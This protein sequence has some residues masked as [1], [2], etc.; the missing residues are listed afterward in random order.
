[1]LA[2]ASSSAGV[3][4]STDQHSALADY[5]REFRPTR[6]QLTPALQRLGNEPKARLVA[7]IEA[8]RAIVDADGERRPYEVKILAEIASDLDAI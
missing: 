2:P 4:L 5:L 3:T 8:A 1:M 7:L 6:A